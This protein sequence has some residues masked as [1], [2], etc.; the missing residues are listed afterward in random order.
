VNL[1]QSFHGSIPPTP[2]PLISAILSERRRRRAGPGEHPHPA[3]FLCPVSHPEN[4]KCFTRVA[5]VGAVRRLQQRGNSAFWRNVIAFLDPLQFPMCKEQSS[6]YVEDLLLMLQAR[7]DQG[8]Q[9]C[10]FHFV[11]FSARRCK[12]V[13]NAQRNCCNPSDSFDQFFV[14]SVPQGIF[15]GSFLP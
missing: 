3:L 6:E 10:G 9:W 14:W 8:R 1:H 2:S 13:H 7:R 4:A 5:E 11:C 12:T 15:W